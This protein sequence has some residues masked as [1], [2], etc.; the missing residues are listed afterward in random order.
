[1]ACMLARTPG[2]AAVTGA[3][4]SA[5]CRALWRCPPCAAEGDKTPLT[6]A[7]GPKACICGACS[8]CKA[9]DRTCTSRPLSS[10]L[11]LSGSSLS[12][13]PGSGRAVHCCSAPANSGC[14][15]TSSAAGWDASSSVQGCEATGRA[16]RGDAS[17]VSP[18]CSAD[19]GGNASS[20]ALGLPHELGVEGRAKFRT[21]TF[22]TGAL[23]GF[24]PC[25]LLRASFSSRVAQPRRSARSEAEVS[26]F[27][28][29]AKLSTVL[30]NSPTS[31]SARK[32][33][34][35]SLPAN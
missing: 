11:L 23:A 7:R 34:T 24:G 1:M 31:F 35:R 6:D 25:P 19:A 29:T 18:T 17:E 8:C 12:T 10:S 21:G 33:S 4:G 14:N 15:A 28:I 9:R 26:E 16:R 5:G 32:R 13:S 3:M 20:A 2:M 27:S 22:A 30:S